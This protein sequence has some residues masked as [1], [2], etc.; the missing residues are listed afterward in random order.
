MSFRS[1]T[2]LGGIRDLEDL[3]L[4]CRI[5]ADTGCWHWSLAL[6]RGQAKVHFVTPDSGRYVC[7]RGPRAALYLALG[8]DLPAGHRAWHHVRCTSADCVNPGHCVSGDRERYGEHIRATGQLRGLPQTLAA[9]TRTARAKFAKLTEAQVRQI[10]LA[11]GTQE[12]IAERFGVSRARIGA[13]RRGEG[14]RDVLTNA[15]VFSFRGETA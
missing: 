11:E 9:N 10:R 15:S 13:I 7:T 8:R 4:R 1:G 14:W 5:D 12:Q 2:Y 3:R 6:D